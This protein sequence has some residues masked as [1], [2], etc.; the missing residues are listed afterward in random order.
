VQAKID[1]HALMLSLT[2]AICKFGSASQFPVYS[3]LHQKFGLKY[4]KYQKL[5]WTNRCKIRL[6][7]LRKF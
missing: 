6:I 1:P 2:L 5:K 3:T 7:E 4:E